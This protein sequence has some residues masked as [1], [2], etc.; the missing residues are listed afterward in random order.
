MVLY[1]LLVLT[2][3]EQLMSLFFLLLSTEDCESGCGMCTLVQALLC[4]T[5]AN[6]VEG[7]TSE[8]NAS[9]AMHICA[10]SECID[11]GVGR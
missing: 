6:G 4:T 3:C 11:W 9:G 10:E 2:D 1:T 5:C 7:Q 8:Q